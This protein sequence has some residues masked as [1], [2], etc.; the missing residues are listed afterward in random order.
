VHLRLE[1]GGVNHP[2]PC[3]VFT[4]EPAP[5]AALFSASRRDTNCLLQ[6]ITQAGA[7]TEECLVGS[8]FSAFDVLEPLRGLGAETGEDAFAGCPGGGGLAI[9]G[10]G[11]AVGGAIGGAGVGGLGLAD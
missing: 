1:T 3:C 8:V 5:R 7:E 9:F 10:G 4:L 11:G 2:F 6:E